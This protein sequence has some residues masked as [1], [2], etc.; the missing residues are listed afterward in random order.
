[1]EVHYESNVLIIYKQIIMKVR[2]K[3]YPS[4]HVSLCP[5]GRHISSLHMHEH[6]RLSGSVERIQ[7][8]FTEIKLIESTYLTESNLSKH[9]F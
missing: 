9:K 1:M 7:Q 2:R 4:F 5:N 3:W 8:Y 6:Q